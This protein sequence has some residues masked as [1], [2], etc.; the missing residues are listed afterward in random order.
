MRVRDLPSGPPVLDPEVAGE[1]GVSLVHIQAMRKRRPK[2]LARPRFLHGNP[3]IRGAGCRS[4]AWS[5]RRFVCGRKCIQ[6][7]C[8]PRLLA[9]G[10]AD[11]GQPFRPLHAEKARRSARPARRGAGSRPARPTERGAQC[12]QRDCDLSSSDSFS[13]Q[14]PNRLIDPGKSLP[15]KT[16][17]AHSQIARIAWCRKKCREIL[18]RGTTPRRHR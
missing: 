6:R 4:H 3:C 14:Q 10:P 15:I 5:A 2:R 16:E 1:R 17:N 11:S 7:F 8:D 13:L 18:D 12:A 9:F